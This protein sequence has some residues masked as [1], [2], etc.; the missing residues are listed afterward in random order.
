VASNLFLSVMNVHYKDKRPGETYFPPQRAGLYKPRKISIISVVQ[1]A[2]II[3][4]Y[5][6]FSYNVTC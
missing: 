6:L 3:T 2:M 1:S 4:S 5:V